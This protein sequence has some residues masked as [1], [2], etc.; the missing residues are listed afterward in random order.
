MEFLTTICA[1]FL[2]IILTK[3]N[4][5]FSG[6]YGK[7]KSAFVSGI[8]FSLIFNIIY[9]M[10]VKIVIEGNTSASSSNKPYGSGPN[11]NG[12]Q[13]R[14]CTPIHGYNGNINCVDCAKWGNTVNGVQ[15]CIG[16]Q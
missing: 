10:V 16:G 11:F 8:I 1:F 14:W 5:H 12:K 2:F 13:S 4:F 6:K 15:Q 9:K 7:I 3:Y